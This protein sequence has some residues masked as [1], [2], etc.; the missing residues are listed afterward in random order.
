MEKS[1]KKADEQA[2]PLAGSYWKR[3]P[4]GFTYDE[5]KSMEKR[6]LEQ[7]E[8]KYAPYLKR[9]EAQQGEI[10]AFKV[11]KARELAFEMRK[12]QISPD[13]VMEAYRRL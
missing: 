5:W 7:G 9:I 11:E 13:M 12:W 1:T 2:D 6:M 4:V 8:T 3:I 10:T